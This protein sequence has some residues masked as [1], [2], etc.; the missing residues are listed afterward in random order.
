[1]NAAVHNAPDRPVEPT[2]LPAEDVDRYFSRLSPF[3]NLALAVSGGADSLCLMV[4]FSE[5]KDRVDWPGSAEV[6]VVDHGLR[7]ESADEAQF[8]VKCAEE[9][10]LLAKSL[11]WEGEKPASNIQD[12]ARRARY[13][14]ISERTAETGAEILLLG[15]HLDDQAETFLDRLSRGSGLYGL[16]A[17]SADETNGPEG[18]RLFRPFLE[19]PKKRLEASLREREQDWCTDPSNSDAK[20]KRSRLRR[21]MSLL[22]DEGLTAERIADAAGHLRR[23]REALETVIAGLAAENLVEHP[24]GPA[25]LERKT[26]CAVEEDLRLRLLSLIV[27]RVTGQHPRIR[28]Q[29]LQA[30]DEAFRSGD[31][32]RHTLAGTLIQADAATIW[33]WR[34]P[35][36]RPPEVLVDP[37]GEGIW[38]HRFA[39]SIDRTHSANDKTD[40]LRLGPLC[41]API[42]AKDIEWPQDWPKEAFDCTPVLWT[43]DGTII[44]NPD[45]PDLR[46]GE[47]DKEEVLSL[48]RIPFRAKLKGNYLDGRDA[49]WE[50]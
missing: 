26:F 32:V 34:E 46:T 31:M 30:L 18:L 40:E 29:K 14:L 27:G 16:G 11:R 21:I 23:S 39:Y 1:M 3:S 36:R 42:R 48:V 13:R 4:L 15:H 43:G 7:A 41:A 20:Y 50:I 47:I 37:A 45:W 25:R 6:I 19:V 5:W 2:G 38:D 8:V 9:A 33:F 35:G 12:A 28:L 10:G 44:A 49:E 22:E 24:A 17:M